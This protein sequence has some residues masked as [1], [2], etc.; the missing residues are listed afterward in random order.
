MH[1]I[2]FLLKQRVM[3]GVVDVTNARLVTAMLEGKKRCTQDVLSAMWDGAPEEFHWTPRMRSYGG[4]D[5]HSLLLLRH[6]LDAFWTDQR[7]EKHRMWEMIDEDDER[8]RHTTRTIASH[9]DHMMVHSKKRRAPQGCSSEATLWVREEYNRRRKH[10]TRARFDSYKRGTRVL[11]KLASGLVWCTTVS[12]MNYGKFEVECCAKEHVVANAPDI[13]AEQRAIRLQ[14]EKEK[15]AAGGAPSHKKVRRMP[16]TV[17]E[18][19]VEICVEAAAA[20]SVVGETEEDITAA[21]GIE[22]H[23]L[24]EKELR[25]KIERGEIESGSVVFG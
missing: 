3:A 24:T 25:E 10:F 11:V 20:P 6:D 22:V 14:R 8:R 16:P 21:F 7:I 23:R 13:K 2:V 1:H 4:L 19:K 18:P 5:L 15:A 17:A 9:S 12:N